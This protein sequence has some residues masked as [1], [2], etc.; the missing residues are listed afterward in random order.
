MENEKREAKKKNPLSH[1]GGI[2]AH[3]SVGK[4][5][6]HEGNERMDPVA[7]GGILMKRR[8]FQFSLPLMSQ[9]YNM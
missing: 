6:E 7:G 3:A 1:V 9:Q 2:N 8:L 5:Q 4:S